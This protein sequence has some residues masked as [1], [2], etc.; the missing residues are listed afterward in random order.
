MRSK[1]FFL[2]L[3]ALLL[4]VVITCGSCSPIYIAR[5]G[6]EEAGILY[7]REPIAELLERDTVPE[8]L[9]KKFRLVL[10][11]REFAIRIGMKPEGSFREFSQI[12]RDV[13]V[14]VLS[15][16]RRDRFEAY[17]WWFP[18]VGS[19]PYKGFFEKE[20]AIKEEERLRKKGL[21]TFVRPS[22]AFSTLGWFDDPLL[23]TITRFDD[24][25]LVNTVL[26]EIL[27]NTIWVKGNAEFNETL[28]NFVGAAAS[29]EFF[30]EAKRDEDAKQA[31]VRWTSELNFAR[32]L[33]QVV[34]ELEELYRTEVSTEA[35]LERRTALLERTVKEWASADIRFQAG[36]LNNA[37]IIAYRI[38]LERPWLFE[39]SFIREGRSLK[40]FL[41]KMKE[42]SDRAA[43]ENRDPFELLAEAVP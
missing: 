41:T 33:D 25:A 24:V 17:T 29:E 38:Y 20:D 35:V 3:F 37:T 15:A 8:L 14:W 39:E 42:L 16:A 2:A 4:V 34:H 13:L 19:I 5:A 1:R 43:A 36:R 23:S 27:H 12:D 32:K 30:R 6:W 18:I 10:E 31:A 28:A 9:K 11:A 21:D 7:R 40:V 22:P 26:H